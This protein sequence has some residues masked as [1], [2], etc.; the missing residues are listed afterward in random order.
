M[1]DR[2]DPVSSKQLTS[3][4]FLFSPCAIARTTGNLIAIHLR[5]SRSDS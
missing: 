2:S 3:F 5:P 1:S 4:F